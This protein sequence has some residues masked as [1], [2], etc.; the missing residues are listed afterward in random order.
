MAKNFLVTDF[1]FTVYTKPAGK[2]RGFFSE[3]LEIG[4]T[5]LNGETF[6]RVADIQS[7][8]KPQFY[9]KQA[10]ESLNFSM[11]TMADLKNGIL[12]PEMIEKMKEHYIPGA[13]YFVAWGD[14]DF[15]VIDIACKRYK[16]ENPVLFSDYLDLAAGYKQLFEKEKTPSLK[17][18]VEEQAVVMEGTWHTALDDAINT[19]K[20]L[21]K[22]LADG[23]DVEAFMSAQKEENYHR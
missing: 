13:T 3:I 14:A 9:V 19:S 4:A 6:D 1:E 21:V 12:F 2:P 23:W 11:I 16:I 18:A 10:E 7:F 15:K 20:L 5:K 8:V 22:L 17:S